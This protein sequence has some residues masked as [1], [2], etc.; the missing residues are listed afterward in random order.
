[1]TEW[2]PIPSALMYEVSDEGRLRSRA[3]RWKEVDR[4]LISTRNSKGYLYVKLLNDDGVRR[5]RFVHKL[6]LEAFVGPRPEGMQTRHLNGNPA[7]NRVVNL[8]WGTALEN[9]QD[10]RSHGTGSS[11]RRKLSACDVEKIAANKGFVLAH[12]LAEAFGVSTETVYNTW[13]AASAGRHKR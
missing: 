2:R 11:G 4:E 7:D 10:R 5:T 9:W 12:G 3:C 1:M 13:Q 6:V 8:A